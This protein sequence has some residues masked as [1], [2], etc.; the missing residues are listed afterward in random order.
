MIRSNQP[1]NWR[2]VLESHM[3]LSSRCAPGLSEPWLF[4]CTVCRHI[5]LGAAFTGFCLGCDQTTN[6]ADGSSGQFI[7]P[8]EPG[9]RWV[10]EHRQDILG[11][12]PYY[13]STTYSDTTY[14][15]TF[16]VEV[17]RPDTLEESTTCMLVSD[18]QGGNAASLWLGNQ[19]DGLYFYGSDSQQDAR[20]FKRIAGRGAGCLLPACSYPVSVGT[21]TGTG[22]P[23]PA[24]PPQRLF[25][26]PYSEGETWSVSTTSM[27][28]T[29][30]TYCGMETIE[31]SAGAALC[32]KVSFT[33]ILMDTEEPIGPDEAFEWVGPCGLMRRYWKWNEMELSD[34]TG[35]VLG[36]CEVCEE[37]T[38]L[39][40]DTSGAAR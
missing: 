16:I 30:K 31:A 19:D 27:I 18:S 34:S 12:V 37:W 25:M 17:I 10:Y 4:A 38:L 22:P 39:H 23:W 1:R 36:T 9:N 40:A 5:A 20:V 7:Y 21:N 6:P 14:R 28:R 35:N 13:D 32:W 24:E 26:Y 8:L 33:A 11:F 15:D 2:P 3:L 29:E